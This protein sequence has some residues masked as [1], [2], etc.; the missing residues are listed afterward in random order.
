MVNNDKNNYLRTIIAPDDFR[1]CSVTF[2]LQWELGLVPIRFESA[3]DLKVLIHDFLFVQGLMDW[4]G[5][6]EFVNHINQTDYTEEELDQF[7][8]SLP[9]GYWMTG[10]II[11]WW[12]QVLGEYMNTFPNELGYW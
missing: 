9:A 8:A 1:K 6:R 4:K 7:W 10:K 5:I 11:R 12:F 3:D 2:G